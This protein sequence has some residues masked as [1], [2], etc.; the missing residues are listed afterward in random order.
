VSHQYRN[1]D[2]GLHRACPL[3][4]FFWLGFVLRVWRL[5]LQSF[6]F[7]EGLTLD[8]ALASPL[9]TFITPRKHAPMH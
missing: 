4:L 5:D 8:L 9:S 6:W 7:D 3:L 1:I 2:R